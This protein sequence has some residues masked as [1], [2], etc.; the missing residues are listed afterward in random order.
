[1]YKLLDFNTLNTTHEVK[2]AY[3]IT[4]IYYLYYY[5]YIYNIIKL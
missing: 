5:K 1:M 2:T 4:H 3:N